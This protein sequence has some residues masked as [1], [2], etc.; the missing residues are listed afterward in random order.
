MVTLTQF[1]SLIVDPAMRARFARVEAQSPPRD[2][3]VVTPPSARRVVLSS[4]ETPV[5]TVIV[6]AWR[7][8]DELLDALEALAESTSRDPFNV[9][10]V[11][12]GAD[13]NVRSALQEQ[14]EGATVIDA[15]VNLGFAGG[16]NLG[17]SR[18][19]GE[20]LV[21]LND[22]A[23]PDSSWLDNLIKSARVHPDAGAICSCVYNPDGS[24][25]EAGARILAGP[26]GIGI[27]YGA[28]TLRSELTIARK[29]DFGGGEALLV[30]RELFEELGGFDQAY[31]PAYFEDA[32]LCLRLRAAGWDIV[33][34]PSAVVTHHQSLSTKED[35]EWREFAFHRS[36][37]VFTKHW[38]ELLPKAAKFDDPPTVLIPIPLAYGGRNLRLSE[39]VAAVDGATLVRARQQEFSEW[40]RGRLRLAVARAEEEESRRRELEAET[41]QLRAGLQSLEERLAAVEQ[42]RALAHV[43]GL[44]L[45]ALQTSPLRTLLEWRAR[46]WLR[47]RPRVHSMV[48]AL[49]AHRR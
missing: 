49:R 15:A 42:L 28:E 46:E 11:L 5:A 41:E 29:V 6:L 34:E 26:S 16:C 44:R 17:A 10:V 24:V 47:A 27:G 9:T 25:Q 3:R 35:Y 21:F 1:G 40:M 19:R 2:D 43:Q 18:A 22:D 38:G 30:R 7:L 45:T 36:K 23:T 12:N 8:I 31:D 13:E 33:Y 20:F 4:T 39:Q 48:A 37:A 14:V 32:D